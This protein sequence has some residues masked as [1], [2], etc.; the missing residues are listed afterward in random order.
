MFKKWI[1]QHRWDEVVR[2]STS[3]GMAEA[4]QATITWAVESF[5]PLKKR[6]KKSTDL[7][8]M[9]KK[10]LK[11]IQNRKRLYWE[12]GGER[13]DAWKQEK[14]R[15]DGLVRERKKGYM[16]TQKEHILSEDA[17]RNFFKHVKNFSLFE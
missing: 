14:R 10:I 12:E 6:Q 8:W 17:N 7:P 16:A 4:Y 3:N 15:I 5:F 2:E 9:S 1:V 11:Q 13:T